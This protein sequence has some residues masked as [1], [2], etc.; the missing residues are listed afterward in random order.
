MTSP[1]H[2]FLF[3][4]DFLCKGLRGPLLYTCFFLKGVRFR[5]IKIQEYANV[6]RASTFVLQAW[7]RMLKLPGP[8]SGRFCVFTM[9][10]VYPAPV[11]PWSQRTPPGSG[12]ALIGKVKFQKSTC[13]ETATKL[14]QWF[15]WVQLLT[16]LLKTHARPA[17]YKTTL[18]PR[19]PVNTGL[20]YTVDIVKA[21]KSPEFG[22]GNFSI[23]NHACNTKVLALPKFAYS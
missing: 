19:N 18:W 13:C 6:G 20:G 14:K 11:R 22:P 1:I 23:R 17:G 7:L 10:A 5:A 3:V 8:N 12:Q 9:S 4:W 21:Q 2:M 15:L 16:L